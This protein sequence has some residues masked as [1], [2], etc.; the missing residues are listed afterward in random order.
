MRKATDRRIHVDVQLIVHKQVIGVGY[1]GVGVGYS[2]V[3]RV[4]ESVA[5][6]H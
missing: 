3:W 4:I 2:G 6:N 1:P 5:A